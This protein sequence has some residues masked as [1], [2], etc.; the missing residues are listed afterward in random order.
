[1]KV[2]QEEESSHKAATGGQREKD[3][4]IPVPR[5]LEFGR[6]VWTEATLRPPQHLPLMASER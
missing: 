2:L 1:M 3:A 6:H 4:E 5:T